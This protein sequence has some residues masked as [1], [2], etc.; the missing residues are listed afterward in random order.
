M[1]TVT[2]L[3]AG[4]GH[5]RRERALPDQLVEAEVVAAQLAAELVG[6]A[7]RVAGRADGL[8]GLLG[9]L[10]LLGVGAGRVGEV[11]AA[12]RSSI[13]W[14]AAAIAVSDSVVQ[15]VRM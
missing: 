13:T 2:V 8:V 11:L 5:L 12:E 14:R 1:R 3:P 4:V 9:V 6:G 15:S 7:E 10:R